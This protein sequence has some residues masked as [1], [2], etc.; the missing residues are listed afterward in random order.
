MSKFFSLIVQV[1]LRADLVFGSALL[2][3]LRSFLFTLLGCMPSAKHLDPVF[4]ISLYSSSYTPTV[5]TL[6][7]KIEEA[8]TME[9]LPT[10]LLLI[11]Q[12]NT[13]GQSQIPATSR[14]TRAIENIINREYH[15]CDRH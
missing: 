1:Q 11:S 12:P 10:G 15:F 6:L 14:E 3:Y 4:P 5:D 13:P 9:Y 7:D 8:R 2:G